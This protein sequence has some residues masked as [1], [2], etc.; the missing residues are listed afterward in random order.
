MGA[1]QHWSVRLTVCHTQPGTLIESPLKS[2]R[3]EK[4]ARG[5]LRESWCY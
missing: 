5:G 1:A 4:S 2:K 3:R